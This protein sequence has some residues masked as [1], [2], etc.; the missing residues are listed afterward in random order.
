MLGEEA[1]KKIAAKWRRIGREL[2]GIMGNPR[3]RDPP[4]SYHRQLSIT[5]SIA[6]SKKGKIAHSPFYQSFCPRQKNPTPLKGGSSLC[7]ILAS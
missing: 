4:H 1:R 7:I 6:P 5:N 3:L 2:N